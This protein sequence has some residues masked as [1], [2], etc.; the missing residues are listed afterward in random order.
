MSG[1]SVDIALKVK[2]LPR[3]LRGVLPL[4]SATEMSITTTSRAWKP[5][6]PGDV[7]LNAQPYAY[8]PAGTSGDVTLSWSHRHRI[9]QGSN[10]VVS[11]EAPGASTLEGTLTVEV[12]IGGVVKRSWT[13]LTSTFQIYTLAQRQ[14]DDAD[15]T[16]TVQFRITPVNGGFTGTVRTTPAFLMS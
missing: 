3:T 12:L 4:T 11:Q 10:T 8:W 13:G 16:K 1:Y 9:A 15:A 2:L 6:P 5:Y 14:A 7:R